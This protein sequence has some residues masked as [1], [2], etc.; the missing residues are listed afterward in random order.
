[1]KPASLVIAFVILASVVIRGTAATNAVSYGLVINATNA[2]IQIDTNFHSATI[3]GPTNIW[4][5][6]ATARPKIG[7][8]NVATLADITA[9]GVSAI[10]IG[11]NNLAGTVEIES[12]A[13]VVSGKVVIAG[14]GV[15]NGAS[16]QFAGLVLGSPT[17]NGILNLI[18]EDF[19]THT[20]SISS[21]VDQLYYTPQTGAPF[22]ILSEADMPG[23][24][25][26]NGSTMTGSLRIGTSG[27]FLTA[28]GASLNITNNTQIGTVLIGATPA[29]IFGTG[30][31][32]AVGTKIGTNIF[33]L[34]QSTI[35]DATN[36]P[37]AAHFE[38][39]RLS[40][41][42]LNFASIFNLGFTRNR[43]I[44]GLPLDGNGQ[45]I[46]NA[47]LTGVSISGYATG[48]PLYA[49]SQTGA[50]RTV[51]GVAPDGSGNVVV[52][53]SAVTTNLFLDLPALAGPWN[54]DSTMLG[55]T[56]NN[57]PA[58]QVLRP[59]TTSATVRACAVNV[60]GT[61]TVQTRSFWGIMRLTASETN[62]ASIAVEHLQTDATTTNQL[63]F[64]PLSQTNVLV[65]GTLTTGTNWIFSG[66][67]F[68]G[69]R[70]ISVRCDTWHAAGAASTNWL[71]NIRSARQ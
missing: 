37:S 12:G 14:G 24:V 43:T 44:L 40:F 23:I 71:P 46:S 30:A 22:R 8:N 18:D 17:L 49:V 57:A 26:R 39:A 15:T 70:E 1:M 52:A 55:P 9:S 36:L 66:T 19:P 35:D 51:N 20:N 65:S 28:N 7:T 45:T 48:T 59:I 56:T 10:K 33:G 54:A 16:P 69:W 47:I 68:S 25:T 42:N 27:M 2:T 6:P 13:S 34:Y 5:F 4:T 64:S 29:G 11:T 67:N 3:T 58:F 21:S 62:W 38:G 31:V 63:Y 50:V 61:N 41:D 60:A 32:S 53:A